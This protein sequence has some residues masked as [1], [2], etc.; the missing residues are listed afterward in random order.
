MLEGE[1]YYLKKIYSK[2]V[3]GRIGILNKKIIVGLIGTVT[4]E[5]RLEGEERVSHVHI[6]MDKGNNL[7]KG[8][9]IG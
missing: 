9:G 6:L 2:V 5:Q 4:C 1:K 3:S 8:T 7:Y